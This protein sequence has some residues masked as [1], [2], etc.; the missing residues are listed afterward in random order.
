MPNGPLEPSAA[1][2]GFA[3]YCFQTFTALRLEGFTESQ[4]LTIVGQVIATA[5][6]TQGDDDG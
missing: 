2:R 4:A 6:L 3:A 1:A 5:A